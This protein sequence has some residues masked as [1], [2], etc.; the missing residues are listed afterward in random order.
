MHVPQN[1]VNPLVPQVLNFPQQPLAEAVR[2]QF[3][4][5]GYKAI[6]FKEKFKGHSRHWPS[7]RKNFLYWKR[8]GQIPN[9]VALRLLLV[10]NLGKVPMRHVMQINPTQLTFDSA[11]QRLTHI[12]GGVDLLTP[13]VRRIL[14]FKV[15]SH[16]EPKQIAIAWQARLCDLNEAIDYAVESRM[17]QII[18]ESKIP[19]EYHFVQSLHYQLS[20]KVRQIFDDWH[21]ENINT[22]LEL[23]YC[24]QTQ[25]FDRNPN[26]D[27][28]YKP[29]A[30]RAQRRS[31]HRSQNT[32]KEYRSKRKRKCW[33][34]DEYHEPGQCVLGRDQQNSGN[35]PK[36]GRRSFY[37]HE[38]DETRYQDIHSSYESDHEEENYFD[39]DARSDELDHQESNSDGYDDVSGGSEEDDSEAELSHDSEESTNQMVHVSPDGHRKTYTGSPKTDRNNDDQEDAE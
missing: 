19:A 29:A 13:A 39:D 15:K 8:S 18:F 9:A 5:S 10:H 37:E 7:F 38:D 1:E 27:A 14:L 34:C 33:K 6:L 30:T 20:G 23:L 32:N 28:F 26:R 31:N 17:D 11:M 3:G 36:K 2:T 4:I 25:Y 12:Y 16:M 24:T 35:Y 21:P 22:C